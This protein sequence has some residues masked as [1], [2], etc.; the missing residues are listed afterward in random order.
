MPDAPTYIDLHAHADQF[1]EQVVSVRNV[2]VGRETPPT[3]GRFYTAG[4]HPWYLEDVEAQ[5]KLLTDLIAQP[6]CIGIGECGLDT[7]CKT[8]MNLQMEAFRHQIELSEQLQKPLIIHCVRSFEAILRLRQIF[9]SQQRWIL[10]GFRNG[11][12]TA[13][14]LLDAG[15]NLSFGAHLIR[16]NDALAQTFRA[17]PLDRLH[18]ETDDS[19]L[20]IEDVYVAAAEIRKVPLYDLMDQ[21]QKN[22]SDVFGLHL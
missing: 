3:D 20:P 4:M 6:R 5:G 19:G 14:Q 11:H 10:H 13:Q 2:V 15:C 12:R 8:P 7:V 18:L 16:A 22:W 21:M 9:P 17:V 1:G